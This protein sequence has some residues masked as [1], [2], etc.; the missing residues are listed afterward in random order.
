[1]FKL[2]CY[3]ENYTENTT[4]HDEHI[5]EMKIRQNVCNN[6]SVILGHHFA[7][8]LVPS[9]FLVCYTATFH[10]A[11]RRNKGHYEKVL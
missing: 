10:L 5:Y 1:M 7:H 11:K 2:M 8:L 4:R 6:A 3:D 9:M